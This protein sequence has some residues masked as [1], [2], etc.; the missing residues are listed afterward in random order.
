MSHLVRDTTSDLRRAL[1]RSIVTTVMHGHPD[2]KRWLG[3]S[4]MLRPFEI[5]PDAE[6]IDMA[7]QVLTDESVDYLL[8]R[9][10][11]Q[12][13]EV[14]GDMFL[15]PECR[16]VGMVEHEPGQWRRCYRCNPAARDLAAA[17]AI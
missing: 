4:L 1:C 9:W 5:M 7:R 13:F 14:A 16:D 8:E 3:E 6:M 15:C 17:E 11:S 10:P 2:L 12:L